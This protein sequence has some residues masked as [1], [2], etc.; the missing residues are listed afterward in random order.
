[1]SEFLQGTIQ[2]AHRRRWG[3]DLVTLNYS[4]FDAYSR[5]TVEANVIAV[6]R[7]VE[8]SLGIATGL[9]ATA[10]MP[11]SQPAAA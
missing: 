6:H 2:I 5:A 9:I 7:F 1:L 11:G 10:T 3:K 8:I 4:H